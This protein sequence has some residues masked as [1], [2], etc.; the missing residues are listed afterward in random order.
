MR[1]WPPRRRSKPA[2]SPAEAAG[3][4]K[5]RHLVRTREVLASGSDKVAFSRNGFFGWAFMSRDTILAPSLALHLLAASAAALLLACA[6][7]AQTDGPRSVES[8]GDTPSTPS[9]TEPSHT[10]VPSSATL[11][12]QFESADESPP[13][14]LPDRLHGGHGISLEYLYTGEVFSNTRGGIRTRRATQYEGLLDLIVAA[15]FQQ[16]GIPLPGRFWIHGQ[17]THGRGLTEDFVG[18]TQ[19]LSNIDSFDN[20]LQ[21]SEYWWQLALLDDRLTFLIGKQD[22]NNNFVVTD[23]ATDFIQSSF[24]ISPDVAIPTFPAQSFAAVIKAQLT[25]S[26][27]CK[28]GIWDGQPDG[29]NW[30]FS[31]SGVTLSVCEVK[32]RYEVGYDDRPG[33]WYLGAVYHSDDFLHPNRPVENRG[34]YVVYF[35]AEQ[36]LW[37]E[38]ETDENG[39]QGLGVF[40]QYSW[41]PPHIDTQH[42]YIGGGLVYHG[43]L[44]CRDDDSM[45]FGVAHAIFSDAPGQSS[46]TAIEW[47]YKAEV[48]PSIVLQPDVQYIVTPSGRE[49]DALLVGLRFEVVL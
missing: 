9:V 45:G 3:D 14:L 18:D 35:G 12:R 17:N 13:G 6:A 22:I 29:G 38:R 11:A 10:H 4:I 27:E 16:A 15:D 24:G 33:N 28:L 44:P 49:R 26:T 7:G 19:T 42:Q 20:I 40:G 48:T 46:E 37:R 31:G 32:S 2:A 8:A 21:V 25:D 41:S 5:P 23:M 30:G 34:N 43:W 1:D 36:M 39:D 47:F